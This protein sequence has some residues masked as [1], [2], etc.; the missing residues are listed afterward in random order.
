[1]SN[2]KDTVLQYLRTLSLSADEAKLYVEL[3][4]KSASHLELARKTG[5]NRT[6]VYRLADQLEK[7]SLISTQTDDRGT[8]LMAADPQTLEVELVTQEEKLKEQRAIFRQLLPALTDLQTSK[9][10]PTNFS[11]QTYE[12]VEGFKQMLW[13]ELKTKDEVV[14]LGSGTLEML[15]PSKRWCEKHRAMTVE[16]NYKVRELVNPGKKDEVFTKNPEFLKH[17]GRRYLSPSVLL[18]EHQVVVYNDT[19]ASYCWVGDQ[20]VGVEI[21]NKANASMMRQMFESYWLLAGRTV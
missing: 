1:M 13:H 11:V 6:K 2:N 19:V 4:K 10:S 15:V 17:Y 5:I 7:R 9:N 16:A 21:I 3:L 20:K 12:G 14:I 8:L 18:M